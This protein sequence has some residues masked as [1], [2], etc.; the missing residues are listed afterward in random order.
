MAGRVD[1]V[2]M[3]APAV[4]SS[5][6][7]RRAAKR[8][9]RTRERV[10][11]AVRDEH[12]AVSGAEPATAVIDALRAWRLAQAR[13]RAV[14]PFVILHDRTLTAIAASL[15]RSIDELHGVPGIGPGKLAAYGESILTVVA[16][17][18]ARR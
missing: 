12:A 1:E 11:V 8:T 4:H 6:T 14:A 10:T 7:G 9:R 15:P 3:A 5:G 13:R 2:R 16:A 17:A 18:V